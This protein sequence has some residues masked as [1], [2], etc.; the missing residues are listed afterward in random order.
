[1]EI[2]DSTRDAA[3]TVL[4]KAV[5]ELTTRFKAGTLST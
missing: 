3:Y 1:V 2:V 5:I 4:A